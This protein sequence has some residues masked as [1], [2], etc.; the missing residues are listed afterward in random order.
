MFIIL[1]GTGHVGS[2]VAMELL[3]QRQPVT[4]VTRNGSDKEHWQERGAHIAVADVSDVDALCRIFRTGKRAFLLNPPAPTST[5]TEIE[6]SKTVASIVAALEGSG[7]EKVVAESTY[8]AQPGRRCGDLNILYDLE[9]A[10]ATQPIPFGIIRA[11]YYFSNWDTALETARKEGVL[12]TMFPA[13]FELPMVAPDDLGR[14]TANLL[15]SPIGRVGTHYVEGPERY[16]SNDVAAAISDV[17]GKPVRVVTTPREQWQQAFRDMGF[18]E[19]AA[20]SYARMTALALDQ[21]FKPDESV[22]GIISLHAYFE[23]LVRQLSG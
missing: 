8:G 20:D 23:N 6:E 7:L 18:S 2:A 11:A 12:H 21:P 10:L 1:G 9:Q 4:I 19:A 3:K 14:F 17:L 16:S 15:A 5:D 22:H 13:D